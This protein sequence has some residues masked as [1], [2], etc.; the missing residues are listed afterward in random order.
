MLRTLTKQLPGT[1]VRIGWQ[2]RS[3]RPC[4]PGSG[5]FLEDQRE[6][7]GDEAG[8]AFQVL[9]GRGCD[10]R[11][12]PTTESETSGEQRVAT[13]RMRALRAVVATRRLWH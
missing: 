13:R 10:H 9:P 7:A 2:G 8:L 6:E 12:Y 3:L 5:F 4:H 1:G 11:K